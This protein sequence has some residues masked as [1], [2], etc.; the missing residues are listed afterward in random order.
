MFSEKSKNQ[1]KLIDNKKYIMYLL[2]NFFIASIV[3][4]RMGNFP[5]GKM[6]FASICIRKIEISR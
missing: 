1:I 6:C 4:F 5:F 3:P 2:I